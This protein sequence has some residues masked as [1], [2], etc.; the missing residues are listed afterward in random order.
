MKN[1]NNRIIARK[2]IKMIEPEGMVDG[3]LLNIHLRKLPTLKLEVKDLEKALINANRF[4][5]NMI[6]ENKDFFLFSDFAEMV[7]ETYIQPDLSNIEI[8]KNR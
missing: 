6:I 3:D 5:N 4:L 2:Q 8:P 1:I 7:N